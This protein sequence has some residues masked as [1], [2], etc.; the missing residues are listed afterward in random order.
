MHFGFTKGVIGHILCVPGVSSQRDGF[1]GSHLVDELVWLK[2]DTYFVKN[3]FQT[4][5]SNHCVLHG[6]A[7]YENPKKQ[8]SFKCQPI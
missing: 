6:F 4:V 2:N 7:V 3:E 8:V 1:S 5:L